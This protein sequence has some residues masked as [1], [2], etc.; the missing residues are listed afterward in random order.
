MENLV[1]IKEI[2]EALLI[3]SENGLSVDELKGAIKEAEDKDIVSGVEILKDEYTNSGRSFNI[4]EIAG[5]YR[6]ITRPEF[7]PWI[8][9]LYSKEVDRI[10]GPSLETLAIIAYKQPLT[11]AEVESIRGVNVGGVIKTL[12]D[13]NLLRIKGRK[14]AVGRPLLYATTEK[15]LEIFGLNSLEDLPALKEFKEEDLEYGKPR[16]QLVPEEAPVPDGGKTLAETGETGYS[17]GDGAAPGE[18]EAGPEVPNGDEPDEEGFSD[19]EDMAEDILD[20]KGVTDKEVKETGDE[21]EK[22]E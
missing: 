1:K 18:A 2:I 19:D 7:L 22:T 10:T 5:K 11:R 4:A 14:D 20:A 13:K 12:L 8:N 3:I 9:N 16:E 15:F 6:I 21:S 17:G